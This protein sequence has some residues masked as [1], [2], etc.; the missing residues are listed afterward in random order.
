MFT[1][2][3]S[4]DQIDARRICAVIADEGERAECDSQYRTVGRLAD[5]GG[6]L[7]GQRVLADGEIGRYLARDDPVLSSW[8]VAPRGGT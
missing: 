1:S 2:K 8:S 7:G 4:L 5:R 6:T 3:F